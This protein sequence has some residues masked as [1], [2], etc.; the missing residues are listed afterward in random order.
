MHPTLSTSSRSAIRLRLHR[1]RIIVGLRY[2]TLE[3]LESE[4]VAL[5]RKGLLR[6]D[7]RQDNTAICKALYSLPDRHFGGSI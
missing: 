7:C 2:L 1:A 4:I 6:A 5:I 3:E